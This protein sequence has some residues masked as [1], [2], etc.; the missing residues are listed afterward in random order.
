MRRRPD[1][2]AEPE[3]CHR[4][5]T[6]LAAAQI[7]TLNKVD[8]LENNSEGLAIFGTRDL[9]RAIFPNDQV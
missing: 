3:A 8:T 5:S 9:A 4:G 2:S 7:A 1:K 6:I